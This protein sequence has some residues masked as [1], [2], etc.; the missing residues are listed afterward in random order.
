MT[1]A[2]LWADYFQNNRLLPWNI[3]MVPLALVYYILGR[4]IKIFLKNDIKR[5]RLSVTVAGACL[6]ITLVIIKMNDRFSYLFDM[7]YGKV[8]GIVWPIVIPVIVFLILYSVSE[9][10]ETFSGTLLRIVAVIGSS[11]MTIMYLHLIIKNRIFIELFGAEY[12]AFAY[13]VVTVIVSLL[14]NY[15]FGMLKHV[16]H[17]QRYISNL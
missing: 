5:L 13:A 4:G 3:D 14:F 16:M 6:F 15:I 2:F 9:L 8:N 10:I 7:K 1:Q 12:N 11:S 17:K